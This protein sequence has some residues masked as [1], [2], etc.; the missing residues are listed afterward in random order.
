[1]YESLVKLSQ[2]LIV[3]IYFLPAGQKSSIKE[4]N[5][6]QFINGVKPSTKRSAQYIEEDNYNYLDL[7]DGTSGINEFE[8]KYFIIGD[9]MFLEYPTLA[10]AKQDWFGKSESE[11]YEELVTEGALICS[12]SIAGYSQFE[13]YLFEGLYYRVWYDEDRTFKALTCSP[14]KRKMPTYDSE[15]LIELPGLPKS[16]SSFTFPAELDCCTEIYSDEELYAFFLEEGTIRKTLFGYAEEGEA[17]EVSYIV[18]FNKEYFL[19]TPCENSIEGRFSSSE[20]V[21]GVVDYATIGKEPFEEI[22]YLRIF[23]LDRE[24]NDDELDCIEDEGFYAWMEENAVY[25]GRFEQDEGISATYVPEVYE[26]LDGFFVLDPN[27]MSV[28]GKYTSSESASIDANEVYTEYGGE[29]E[30]DYED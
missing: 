28:T 2:K 24:A 22:D 25:L 9:G 16:L 5:H 1:L 20:M 7:F 30:E 29:D 10:A 14:S 15:E 13:D 4:G 21:L 6:M 3:S 26:L 11:L 12:R 27:E 8:G 19:A 23:S 17:P 18:E